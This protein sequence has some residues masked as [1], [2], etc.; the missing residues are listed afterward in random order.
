MELDI[1]EDTVLTTMT[2]VILDEPSNSIPCK[3][4]SYYE[5]IPDNICEVDVVIT[6][7]TVDGIPID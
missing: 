6:C 7:E 1:C 2:E 5:W 4:T 3:D